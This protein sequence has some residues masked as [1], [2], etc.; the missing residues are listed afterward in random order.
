MTFPDGEL[1][2]MDSATVQMVIE[3]NISLITIV[4]NDGESM[5]PAIGINFGIV[6]LTEMSRFVEDRDGYPLLY[7]DLVF[8]PGEINALIEHLTHVVN[9]P[10]PPLS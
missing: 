8:E 3:H 10:N 7:H 4:A 2:S 5:I 1:V 9:L 6:P